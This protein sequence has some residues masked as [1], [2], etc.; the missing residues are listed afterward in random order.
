MARRRSLDVGN[1]IVMA[2]AVF[3]LAYLGLLG[4]DLQQK[5]Q[6]LVQGINQQGNGPC[7][8][9]TATSA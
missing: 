9:T 7:T 4:S 8:R 5:A 3:A 1:I 2:G 6:Q